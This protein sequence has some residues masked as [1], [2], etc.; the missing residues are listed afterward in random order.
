MKKVCI[1]MV[2]VVLTAMCA[3]SAYAAEPNIITNSKM[4]RI[5]G[6]N[7]VGTGTLTIDSSQNASGEQGSSLK[8][9]FSNGNFY[10]VITQVNMTIGMTYTISF[11]AKASEEGIRILPI[12]FLQS[13]YDYMPTQTASIKWEHYSFEYTQPEVNSSG[14]KVDGSGTFVLRVQDIGTVWLDNVKIV[15]ASYIP[16]NPNAEQ[17]K[18]YE[19]YHHK[20]EEHKQNIDSFV[21]TKGHWAEETINILK[22]EKAINGVDGFRYEP[23]RTITRAEFLTMLMLQLNVEDNTYNGAYFDVSDGEWYAAKIQNAKDIGL[24]S[25]LITQDGNFRPNEAITREDACVL[26]ESYAEYKGYENIRSRTEFSDDRLISVYARDSVY[27][28]CT[29][30]IING[31]DDGSFKPQ[32]RLTRAEA[33]QILLNI[34][35]RSGKIAIYVDPENGSDINDGTK[36]NPFKTV[37]KAQAMVRDVSETMHHNIYV[38]IKAGEYY[39]DKPIELNTEDSGK[40]DCSVIYTSYGD[41]KACF[42]GGRHI[43]TNWQIDNI[44]KGIYK[45]FVGTNI[46]TRQMFVNGLRMTRARTEEGFKTENSRI[47]DEETGYVTDDT[48]F[49]T[50]KNVRDMELVYYQEWTNPRCGVDKLIKNNDGTITLIMEKPC[51]ELL[52]NK[53]HLKISNPVYFENQYEFIDEEGEWYI[54]NDG[55]LYFKPF[56]FIDLNTADIVL[57]VTER[58]MNVSGNKTEQIKN[59]AFINIGFKYAGWMRP[60]TN[61]GYSDSQGGRLRE[62]GEKVPDSS[63]WIKYVKNL[64]VMDCEFSKMGITALNVTDWVEDTKIVGNN[65]YDLSGAGMYVGNHG[66]DGG[67]SGDAFL[68]RN[69][70]IKNNIVHDYGIDYGS[71]DAIECMTMSYADIS[72]NEVYNGRYSGLTLGYGAAGTKYAIDFTHNYVHDVLNDKI[73]DG[74]SIYVTKET[75]GTEERRNRVSYNYTSRQGNWSANLYNDNASTY[76]EFDHN[77]VNQKD[78]PKWNK[79]GSVMPTESLFFMSNGRIGN[80]VH[81]N[82]VTT[83]HNSVSAMYLTEE[84]PVATLENNYEYPDANWPEE[85]QKIIDESGL[86]QQYDEKYPSGIEVVDLKSNN[87]SLQT[88]EKINIKEYMVALGRKE[89]SMDLSPLYMIYRTN[90]PDIISVSEDGTITSLGKGEAELKIT[91]VNGDMIYRKTAKIY[92]GDDFEKL[93]FL[94]SEVQLYTKTE[95]NIAPTVIS[96]FGSEYE[97]DSVSYISDDINVASVDSAGN[98]KA[99]S[100][101]KAAIHIEGVWKNEKK[102][103]IMPVTVKEKTDSKEFMLENYLVTN[104]NNAVLDN[105]FWIPGLKN[106]IAFTDENGT[107]FATPANTVASA[108]QYGEELLH[109]RIRVNAEGGWPSINLRVKNQYETYNTNT[110][111]M[112]TFG[113][114]SISV[115]KFVLGKRRI[116]ENG[117]SAKCDFEYNKEYDLIIGAVNHEDNV[118]IIVCIEG[119]PILR[120]CDYDDNRI[121]EA[122]YI[123][124]YARSGSI[125]LL[126]TE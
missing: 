11:D 48:Y 55:W 53:E 18:Y 72:N 54:S 98:V 23:D 39:I 20:E 86:E 64:T 76:W 70:L 123:Q 29:K 117:A 92:S 26:A 109:T 74:G 84:G 57:P 32:G 68:S 46:Q 12:R 66:E 73:F 14:A 52:M 116:F 71:S 16:E 6:W 62:N 121:T 89:V 118:E 31:F 59:I 50:Y 115:Q 105:S 90:R 36:S 61:K 30:N 38:M 63:V 97:P 49:A 99:I 93:K 126:K 125:S 47:N 114:G 21:D 94:K 7:G 1:L 112:V 67:A 95:T 28:A 107:T 82:Y 102:S 77:V 35:E 9:N 96:A 108:S 43:D 10:D 79:D 22:T 85:A 91:I 56:D 113:I 4:D 81:D 19:P 65:L 5:T 15:D 83:L 119:K 34:I 75:S 104:W 88:G 45:T 111:Y 51:W 33:A 122:G 3:V 101:G 13:G 124:M 60:S 40:N 25:S 87:I 41:G 17:P 8:V 78:K 100:P 58:L 106:D 120:F 80:I 110:S 37:E 2:I 27:E 42:S 24:I 69:I 103:Y 44:E